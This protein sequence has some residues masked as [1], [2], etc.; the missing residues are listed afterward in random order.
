MPFIEVQNLAKAYGKIQAV[1]DFSFEVSRGEIY[2]LVGPDGAGKTTVMRTLCN[3]LTADAGEASIDG[4]NLFTDFDRVKPLLGYMPQQFSLYPDLSVEE[5]L[6][7]Y[8][9]LHGITG[10]AYRERRDYL[11]TFNNLQNFSRRRAGALSGGMK[12]KLALSSALMHNPKVLILDEPTTGVDPLSRRQFW[13]ILAQLRSEGV[14]MVVST[15]YMDEVART[16]RACFIFAGTKLAEGKPSELTRLFEGSVYF[17]DIEPEVALV[18]RLNAVDH[19]QARRFGAA[20]HLYLDKGWPLDRVS[21]SLRG[22]GVDPG[23]LVPVEPNLEDCFI[24]LLGG[25]R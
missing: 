10:A 22:A 2:A 9:G 12:Q 15:P 3:L 4:V 24:Q 7:F 6:T 21:E 16:D 18:K 13:E 20:L 8:A 1:K 5:N 17:L 14:S 19:V 25:Q 11:Y 23:V